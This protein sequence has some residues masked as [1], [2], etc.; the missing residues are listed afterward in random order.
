MAASRVIC[1]ITDQSAI[2]SGAFDPVKR[3]G[4]GQELSKGKSG[5]GVMGDDQRGLSGSAQRVRS[6]RTQLRP[7]GPGRTAFTSAPE[8][9][10]EVVA[11]DVTTRAYVG[12]VADALISAS[13]DADGLA[14][15][16]PARS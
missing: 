1:S 4:R 3:I 13:R 16:R 9:P 2:R 6:N 8:T 5:T 12:Q 11:I 7:S 14:I 15:P 10:V